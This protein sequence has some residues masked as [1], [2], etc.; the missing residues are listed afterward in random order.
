V[1]E[2]NARGQLTATVRPEGGRTELRYV[3]GGI[4]DGMLSGVTEDPPAAR[5]V[6]TVE[7]DTAG[8]TRQI[9]APG[10]RVK[11]LTCNALGQVE[12]VDAPAVDGLTATVRR[13]FDDSGGVVRVERPAGSLAAA[14]AGGSIVHEFERDE[15]GNLRR[16]TMAINT[17]SSRGWLLDLDHAGHPVSTR[18]PM[19]ARGE[20]I[21]GEN[22]ALLSTTAA[23][24]DSAAWTMSYGH[25]RAGRVTRIAGP[26]KDITQIEYDVWGRPRRITQPNGAVRVLE[27]GAGD[28]LLEERVE[29]KMLPGQ[30]PSGTM[31]MGRGLRTTAT[32]M[33]SMR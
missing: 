13:W 9:T 10:G 20:A 32:P 2:H 30:T 22:G 5:L 29:A 26:R 7:Y 33:N 1:F 15:L 8:F 19:G 16:A 3:S 23:A 14:I 12:V 11:R 18:D 31:P 4:H 25:D 24:G 21:F 6:T 27:F 28:R 17:S